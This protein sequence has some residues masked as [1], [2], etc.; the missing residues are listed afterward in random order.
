MSK[1][2]LLNAH[3]II[4]SNLC[5]CTSGVLCWLTKYKLHMC[6]KASKISHAAAAMMH[7]ANSTN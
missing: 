4:H 1:I 7:T 5:A 3:N 2:S 6:N